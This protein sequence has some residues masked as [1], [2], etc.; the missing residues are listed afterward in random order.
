M[1]RK[2]YYFTLVTLKVDTLWV[3]KGQ[4]ENIQ[5]KMATLIRYS[6]FNY[7]FEINSPVLPNYSVFWTSKNFLDIFFSELGCTL[8]EIK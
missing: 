5:H 4:S 1:R 8:Q 6:I 3:E 7:R 2:L